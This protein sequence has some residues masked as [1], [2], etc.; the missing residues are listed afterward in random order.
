MR[1]NSEL[2]IIY[3]ANCDFTF[4]SAAGIVVF[5]DCRTHPTSA[6]WVKDDTFGRSAEDGSKYATKRAQD[7]SGPSPCWFIHFISSNSQTGR[8]ILS[9]WF[10]KRPRKTRDDFGVPFEKLPF[11]HPCPDFRPTSVSLLSKLTVPH[12]VGGL[13]IGIGRAPKSKKGQPG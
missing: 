1:E 4:T 5:S 10:T 6:R 2:V 12:P 11:E 13:R 7:T 9:H 3:P 8:P